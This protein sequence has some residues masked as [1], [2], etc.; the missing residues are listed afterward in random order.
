MLY[1]EDRK[2][3]SDIL[4]YQFTA[5]LDVALRRRRRD[6]IV[7][8]QIRLE[9][10]AAAVQGEP[11]S[12]VQ[13]GDDLLEKLPIMET[14]ESTALTD[15]LADLKE[16]ERLILLERAVNET[17]FEAL[18]AKTGLTYQGVAA[19]YHRAIK[20]VKKIMEESNGI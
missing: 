3:G 16:R 8:H 4:R 5:F 12:S 7:S 17:S 2:S 6:Y 13:N 15:A 11:V 20:K 18:A 9:K 19:V 14:L 1:K 10:E